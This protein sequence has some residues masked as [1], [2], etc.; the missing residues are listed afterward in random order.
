MS[1]KDI[2]QKLWNLCNILRDDGITY[3]QYVT[4]LTYILFLKMINETG[5]EDRLILAV[6]DNYQKGLAQYAKEHDVEIN[7]LNDKECDDLKSLLYD[8][9]WK[10][11]TKLE[12]L[13]LK[14]YYNSLLA[15][16]GSAPLEEIRQIYEKAVSSIDEPRNLKKLITEIA[17]IVNKI[18]DCDIAILQQ[19]WTRSKTAIAEKDQASFF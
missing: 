9:S 12:G 3:H 17:E 11:L 8:Y 13:K 1:T 19:G 7:Q 14:Q 16:L 4:E 10:K 6:R 18:E 5:T 2:V 15:A